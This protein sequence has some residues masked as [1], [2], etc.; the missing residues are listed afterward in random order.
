MTNSA[1]R[2]VSSSFLAGVTKR[3]TFSEAKGS[4][5]KSPDSF[6][7]AR[8]VNSQQSDFMGCRSTCRNCECHC[9]QSL[10]NTAELQE[11]AQGLTWIY[12]E[13]C[14][15]ELNGCKKLMRLI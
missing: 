14:A 8:F 4:G 6:F 15:W 1:R 12:V 2:M 13:L 3:P 11:S 5:Q 7:K 9:Y 10:W